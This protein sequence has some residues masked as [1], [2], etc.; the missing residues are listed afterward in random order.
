[1]IRGLEPSVFDSLERFVSAEL[2]SRKHPGSSVAVVDGDEIVWSRGFGYANI[3]EG[4]EATPETIYGCAS[5]TKTVVTFGFLQ[6]MEAGKFN[7]DDPVNDHLDVKIKTDYDEEPVIRDL[8]THYTGMPTRVPPLFY[9]RDRALTL[10]EYIAEAARTVRPPRRKWVYCNTSYTILGRLIEL[11]TGETYDRYIKNNVLEPLEMRFSDFDH[12]PCVLERLARGY[13]RAGGPEN[14][15]IPNERYVLGTLPQDPAGSLYSTVLD[16]GNFVIANLNGGEFK[17]RRVLQEETVEEMHRLQMSPGK[18]NSGMALTWFRNMHD[19]HVMLSHTG[20]L[21]DYANHV[22]FYPELGIGICWL[23]NLRDD[24]VWRP[25]APTA[26]RILAG[27]EAPFNPSRIQRIPEN[28]KNLIGVYGDETVQHNLR[29]SNGYMMLDELILE[30]IDESR[31]MVHGSTNDG[32]E[33]TFEF[34]EDGFVR[35]FDLGNSFFSRYI[36]EKVEVEEG[37]ELEGVWRGEYVNSIGFHTLELEIMG[38]SEGIAIDEDGNEIELFEFSAESGIVNGSGV[39][40]IPEEYARWG[41]LKED[42]ISLELKA[43]HGGLK[44]LLK[45]AFGTTLIT[46]ERM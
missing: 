3:E 30:E 28:W 46:F 34:G 43:V 25:P 31:Y 40:E 20:G 9:D 19:G 18:S 15:L 11:W 8:L 44:G 41:V 6:L 10:E 37:M 4:L 33:L 2:E 24:S 42:E 32:Y 21:P 1:M 36:E 38:S 27:E 29:F 7:L 14:P 22:A 12:T 26:L 5:V 39:F 13:K 17:G 23:S 35:Q 16:L 45:S